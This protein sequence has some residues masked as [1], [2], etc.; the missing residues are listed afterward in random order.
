MKRLNPIISEPP[1]CKGCQ[2]R[3]SACHDKCEKYGKW[4]E[5]IERVKKSRKEFED[6]LF[7]RS[8]PFKY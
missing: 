6:S 1:P 8:D 2:L 5:K 7:V 3:V 4:K